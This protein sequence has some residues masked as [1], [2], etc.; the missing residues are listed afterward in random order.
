MKCRLTLTPHDLV[1]VC[2]IVTV[3]AMTFLL[4]MTGPSDA[5]IA[6]CIERTRP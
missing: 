3:L 2:V 6:G 1:V 4:T 5:D